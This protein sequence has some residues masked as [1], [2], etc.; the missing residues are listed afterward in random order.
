MTDKEIEILTEI[1]EQLKEI[2]RK[3]DTQSMQLE[4]IANR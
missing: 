2:S 4:Q 3:L 1:L